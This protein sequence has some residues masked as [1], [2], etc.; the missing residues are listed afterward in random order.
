MA[1]STEQNTFIL[2]EIAVEELRDGNCVKGVWITR[3][4]QNL[5][6][7]YFERAGLKHTTKQIKNRFTTLKRWYV[8]W[9]WL[10]CQT[11]KGFRENGEIAASTAWW[12]QKISVSTCVIQISF[13]N[14][15]MDMLL[16]I[17]FKCSKIQMPRNFRGAILS[18]WTCS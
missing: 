9:V 17:K 5:K 4:Y 6:D 15:Y 12:N 11:G 18:T 7:K 10:G 3:G 1:R 13:C 14:V 16:T 8:A 2:C